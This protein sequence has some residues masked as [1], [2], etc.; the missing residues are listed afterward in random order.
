MTIA[1]PRGIV[2]PLQQTVGAD[3]QRYRVNYAVLLR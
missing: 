1:T 3:R 2:K